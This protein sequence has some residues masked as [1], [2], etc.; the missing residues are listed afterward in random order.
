MIIGERKPFPEIIE[1]LGDHKN[2]LVLG[3][4]TC[5]SVCFAGGE[6]EAGI[7]A[8]EL[9]M[10][11]KLKDVN[12]KVEDFTI[13]R[14]CETEFAET[15]RDKVESADVILSL[16]CG[17]GVQTFAE[18]F[19]DKIILPG[20]NTTFIGWP[21]EPG[22]WV[23]NCKSCGNCVLHITDGICPISQ[24]PKGLLNGPCK[25]TSEDGKCEVDKDQYCAWYL[26]YTRL[27]DK[28]K[29]NLF[30]KIQP[31]FNWQTAGYGGVRKIVRDDLTMEH[32]TPKPEHIKN[33]EDGG[34]E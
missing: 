3:C 22:I 4:G 30:D 2:I 10:A 6:K 9:R 1:M 28:N 17:I 20:V 25:G 14:Q 19:P 5:V 7:L 13:E 32:M 18:I 34:E 31:A 29:L 23:E 15:I 16:A 11:G 33:D 26:I 21:K 12:L 24:C 27:K 8:A